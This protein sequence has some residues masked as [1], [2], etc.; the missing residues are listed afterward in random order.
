MPFQSSMGLSS[1][2]L[3]YRKKK[4]KKSKAEEVVETVGKVEAKEAEKR[5]PAQIAY[6]KVQEQRVTSLTLYFKLY[7]HQD[8]LCN[9]LRWLIV[10][11][12]HGSSI[13]SGYKSVLL[14][15]L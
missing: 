5:T 6:E 4:K 8:N 13:C 1:C 11:G 2:L 10:R 7:S 3:L 15:M 14:S 12:W 9:C